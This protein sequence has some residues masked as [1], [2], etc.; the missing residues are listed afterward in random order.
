MT[1]LETATQ[2]STSDSRCWAAVNGGCD[3]GITAEHIVTHAA[4]SQNVHVRGFS[5]CAET[6]M[7]VG[8]AGLTCRCLCRRHNNVLSI[9]DEEFLRFKDSLE[10]AFEQ[11]TL[12]GKFFVYEVNGLRL[13]RWLAKS[14]CTQAAAARRHVP[15]PLAIYAFAEKDDPAIRVYS[16]FRANSGHTFDTGH[17]GA[18]WL[19]DEAN[20]D[21]VAVHVQVLDFPFI[22]STFSLRAYWPAIATMMDYP[23]NQVG[24]LVD[25]LARVDFKDRRR[26]RG[27]ILIRWDDSYRE[28]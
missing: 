14:L 9:V 23:A 18:R 4:L 6:L 19:H 24:A 13:A 2:S 21:R 5:W 12:P 28:D 20:P 1:D 16:S 3:G 27:C 22:L 17:F 10:H 11:R 15:R 26:S 25:R 7:T 8:S